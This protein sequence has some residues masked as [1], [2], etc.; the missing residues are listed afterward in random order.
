MI[1]TSVAVMDCVYDHTMSVT[2]I[3]IAGTDLM[4]LTAVSNY[5]KLVAVTNYV[6]VA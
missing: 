2:D 1:V 6:T 5:V 4:K 3:M